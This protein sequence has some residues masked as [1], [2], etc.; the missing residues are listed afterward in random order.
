[1]GALE[2]G[3][4]RRR[5]PQQVVAGDREPLAVWALRN[6]AWNDYVKPVNA[7]EPGHDLTALTRILL[8]ARGV[9][10][11][12]W[13]AR[14]LPADLP[15]QRHHDCLAALRPALASVKRRLREQ[16]REAEVAQRCGLTRIECSR[17][18]RK[19]F[20]LSD[21]DYVRQRRIREARRLLRR[22]GARVAD[23]CHAV[24]FNDPSYFGRV[25][26]QQVGMAPAACARL[27]AQRSGADERL[28][29]VADTIVTAALAGPI[30]P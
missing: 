4:R 9:H 24:G 30:A 5:R 25:F 26:R 29:D 22:P 23:V 16:V 3:G 1:M 13:P 10:A 2:P 20:G 15:A 27:E 21:I 7:E 19:A 6:R 14:D 11:P 8:S 18:C 17:A 12:D 28:P